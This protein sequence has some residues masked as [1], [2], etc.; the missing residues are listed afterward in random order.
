MAELK[1]PHCGEVFKVDDSGYAAILQQVRGKEFEQELTLRLRD[2]LEKAQS[3]MREHLA[4]VGAEYSKQLSD[5]Q[6][7]ITKLESRVNGFETEKQLAVSE[8]ETKLRE[9]IAKL[10]S[11]AAKVAAE[12]K[13]TL[14]E[15]VLKA[16]QE[17]REAVSAAEKERYE[18]KVRY[19]AELKIK[20]EQIEQYRDY[21][22][23]QSTKMVGESLEQHCRFE[24][25]K[26]RPMMPPGVY[27]EKDNKVS[28][29][30]GSKGDFIFRETDSD[31]VEILSIMFEM[32]NEM[33]STE[34]KHKNEDFLK[35][36][37]KDRREK[38]CEYAVLVTLLEKDNDYYNQG[39]VDVSHRYEK[40]YVIRPQFF[41]PII[42]LLR[43]AA[44]NAY[45][46]KKQL[47]SIK[48][49]NLDLTHF[50]ENIGEFARLFSKH[51]S[52]AES[53]FNTA[54][55]EIDSCIDHLGKVKTALKTSL[56]HMKNANGQIEK[57][58]NVKA[59]TRN[60]PAVAEMF[61]DAASAKL[62]TDNNTDNN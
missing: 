4:K 42:T 1:C 6:E 19:E 57:N 11:D 37:D 40:M 47:D 33:E 30:S 35:E 50:E 56:R 28:G 15:V 53:Q 54:I 20:D 5:K 52:N 10:E 24:F 60:A 27:F 41:I 21:T 7:E 45:S 16:E 59:L 62:L 46:Y 32:K 3:D 22:V 23:R 55:E 8:A 44:M 58:L 61:D 2:K 25:D 49:Q 14:N 36:L 39:I 48:K 26:I 13:L 29:D 31:G 18:Q 38:G 34:K 51:Y 9:Q 17:K 12:N 43:S